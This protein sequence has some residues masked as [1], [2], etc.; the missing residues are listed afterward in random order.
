MVITGVVHRLVVL[1]TSSLPDVYQIVTVPITPTFME[2]SFLY[3]SRA[4]G[5][6][7]S[8]T[9]PWMY[10]KSVDLNSLEINAKKLT[11]LETLSISLWE[12][13]TD[14]RVVQVTH[15]IDYT[16]PDP[17]NDIEQYVVPV[18]E[19]ATPNSVPLPS[20]SLFGKKK[21][22]KGIEPEGVYVGSPTV[23]SL[24]APDGSFGFDGYVERSGAGDTDSEFWFQVI[25]D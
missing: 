3:M 2:N 23:T 4:G 13:M 12:F 9:N 25:E 22:M 15:A 11:Q 10:R 1:D 7:V 5:L 19:L 16:E 8:E 18:L 20:F 6:S 17:N 21:L 14:T 24:S